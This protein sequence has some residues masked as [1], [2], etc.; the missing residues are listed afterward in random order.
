MIEG[1]DYVKCILPRKPLKPIKAKQGKTIEHDPFASKVMHLLAIA[2]EIT[3]GDIV[4]QTKL[5]R[6]TAG[7]KINRLLTQKLIKRLGTGRNAR[8]VLL[9]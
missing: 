7:R 6:A 3:M 9:R 8:Y 5:P 1:D 2:Q 4:E